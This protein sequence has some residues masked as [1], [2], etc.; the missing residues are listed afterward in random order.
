[1]QAAGVRRLKVRI[2]D[3]SLEPAKHS[4]V[5]AED[6]RISQSAVSQR[7]LGSC[8]SSSMNTFFL[9]HKNGALMSQ[10]LWARSSRACG[11]S[12][13]CKMRTRAGSS[14]PVILPRTVHGRCGPRDCC[15]CACIFRNRCVS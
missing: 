13:D 3:R 15:G 5:C 2:W 1:M 8:K 7:G 14:G 6:S 12:S 11:Q 10:Y 9:L 4:T